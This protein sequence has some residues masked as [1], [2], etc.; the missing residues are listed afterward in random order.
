ML[1]Q[2]S[3]PIDLSSLDRIPERSWAALA[4]TRIYF[5]HQSVGDNILAGM[6]QI[7]RSRPVIRLRIMESADPR[8]LAEPVLAHSH[9]GSNGSPESKIR[10]F[11]DVMR[12]GAGARAQ[13]AMFKLCYADIE[14]HTD[15]AAVF[16]TYKQTLDELERDFPRVQFAHFTVPLTMIPRGPKSVVKRLFGK[17]LWGYEQNLRRESY[18][19]RIRTTYGPRKRL[20]DVAE[21][22]ANFPDGT[23]EFFTWQ[24]RKCRALAPTFTEDGGHLGTVGRVAVARGMLSWLA[25]NAAEQ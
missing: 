17:P 10:A 19:E 8:S 4:D 12:A 6:T 14:S 18:N 24:G 3:T 16:E 7:M 23:T 5:G 2:A 20:I 11:A 22:E 9:L 1:E 25:T 13:V 15:P 21:F